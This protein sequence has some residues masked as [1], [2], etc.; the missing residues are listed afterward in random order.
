VRHHVVVADDAD[1]AEPVAPGES[2]GPLGSAGMTG[3]SIAGP[4]AAL[5]VTDFLNAAY[6]ARDRGERSL[7]DLRLARSILTTGWHRAGY[8]HLIVPSAATG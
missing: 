5:W 7:D 4:T 3:S 1:R 6:Y 2:T 8:R